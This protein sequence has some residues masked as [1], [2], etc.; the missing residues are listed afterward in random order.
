M[1]VTITETPF[2]A[3]NR[4]APRPSTREDAA[5]KHAWVRHYAAQALAAHATLQAVAGSA[6]SGTRKSRPDIGYLAL[7]GQTSV[8]AAVAFLGPIDAPTQLWDLTPELGALN[9]EW[10]EWLT[11][12]LVRH[13]V[14]PGHIDPAYNPADFAEAVQR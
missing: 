10:E 3:A 1:T 13:G 4:L 7:L 14:N 2:S 11:S 8:A 9:G 12:V 6:A 5:A